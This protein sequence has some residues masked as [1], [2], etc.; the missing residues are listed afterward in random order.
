M[1]AVSVN[2]SIPHTK[3]SPR[4]VHVLK[5]QA[6]EVLCPRRRLFFGGWFRLTF[7]TCKRRAVSMRLRRR[8]VR[9][10]SSSGRPRVSKVTPKVH[11]WGAWATL[12]E[13]TVPECC[14]YEKHIIFLCFNHIRRV[15]APCF[16]HPVSLRNVAVAQFGIFPAFSA[17]WGATR[18]PKGAQ[19]SPKASQSR[20]GSIQKSS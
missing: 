8:P 12:F 19:R 6:L 17:A 20:P 2:V 1:R 18:C 15:R 9:T 14:M 16:P 3:P 5:T 11:F 7:S 4:V 10:Q 13:A